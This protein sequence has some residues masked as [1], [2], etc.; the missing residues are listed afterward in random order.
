[1][2]GG[3]KNIKPEDGKQFSKEYQPKEKWTI[4]KAEQVGKDLIEWMNAKNENIFFE[5][6][7]ILNNDYYPQLI[8]YLC[9]KFSSFLKLIERA[10][11]IQEIK[12][13]KYGVGDELNASMT[14]FVLINEHQKLSE[15]SKFEHSGEIK[16]NES[17][18]ITYTD[19]LEKNE[20]DEDKP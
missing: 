11:K 15:N 10:K 8:A 16:G 14:K 5:E 7:L 12:L 4:K 3:N 1:M 6:F 18:E 13:Y 19:I 17:L 9:E 2:P 20:E